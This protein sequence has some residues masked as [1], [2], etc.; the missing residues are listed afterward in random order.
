[1]LN[2]SEL[3][4]LKEVVQKTIAENDLFL[5]TFRD[6]QRRVYQKGA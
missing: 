1:V 4:M 2:F 3:S 5:S 6:V